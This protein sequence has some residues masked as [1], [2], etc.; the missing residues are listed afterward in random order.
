MHLTLLFLV[1]LASDPLLQ[2]WTT[3]TGLSLAVPEK[4]HLQP[5]EGG[6][7]LV[8]SGISL[9]LSP[10]SGDTPLQAAIDAQL[11]PFLI[12]GSPKP[13]PRKLSCTLGGKPA[14]CLEATVE[15]A[16]GASLRLLAGHRPNTD[17]TAVCLQRAKADT[18]LCDAVLKVD[19]S[20]PR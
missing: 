6:V 13:T 15:V 16:P 3:R 12:T 7:A 2:T 20:T 14:T 8:G 17:W 10:A 5:A 9:L 1:A 11:A 18:A 19:M 4:G